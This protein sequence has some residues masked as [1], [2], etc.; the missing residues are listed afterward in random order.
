MGVAKPLNGESKM[1]L[2]MTEIKR[3]SDWYYA[4]QDAM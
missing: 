2:D 4:Y 3:N 1:A